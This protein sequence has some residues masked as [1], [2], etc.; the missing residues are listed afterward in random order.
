VT[1]GASFNTVEFRI[2]QKRADQS[3][4][5]IEIT[6]PSQESLDE[7]IMHLREQGAE[8]APWK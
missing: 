5:R 3:F 6:A 7:L 4:A 1:Q 2:G 8:V